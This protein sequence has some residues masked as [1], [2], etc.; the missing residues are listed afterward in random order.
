LEINSLIDVDYARTLY[1]GCMAAQSGA[2]AWLEFID[3][4][5]LDEEGDYFIH[6]VYPEVSR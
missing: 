3:E 2:Y 6:E 5:G 4:T 1:A